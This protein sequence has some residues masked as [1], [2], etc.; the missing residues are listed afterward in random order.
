V[1]VIAHEAIGVNEPI[2]LDAGLVECA[3]EQLV[4]NIIAEYGF[5]AISSIHDVVDRSGV[6]DAQLTS[7]RYCFG[8][9]GGSCKYARLAIF[10]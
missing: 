9:T 10:V 3:E 5:T 1:E 8:R 7:H 2:G 6:L 4:I